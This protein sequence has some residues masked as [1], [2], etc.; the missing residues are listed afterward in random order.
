MK[1][2]YCAL[3]FRRRTDACQ[4]TSG[5]TLTQ[6]SESKDEYVIS[7]FSKRLSAAEENYSSNDRKLLGLF[8]FLKPFHWS[9]VGSKFEVTTD[10]QIL[11]S[12]FE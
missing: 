1:A 7:Y 11:Q 9:V 6:T 10:N 12:V 3:H 2:H 8:C 5:D 4:L